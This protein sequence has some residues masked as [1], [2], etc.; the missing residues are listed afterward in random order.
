[1][2]NLVSAIVVPLLITYIMFEEI[3][4]PLSVEAEIVLCIMI[5]HQMALLYKTQIKSSKYLIKLNLNAY[6]P[7]T[8]FY[9]INITLT[10]ST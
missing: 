2:N 8:Q 5:P 10:N 7:A 3:I 4:I 9:Y 1:M 6:F